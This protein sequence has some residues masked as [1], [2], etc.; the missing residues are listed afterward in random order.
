MTTNLI[1]H[2]WKNN[3]EE[4]V[5]GEALF[6]R[7]AFRVKFHIEILISVYPPSLQALHFASHF[8][9]LACDTR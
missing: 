8:S 1:D 6:I 4:H 9:L 7:H 3:K 2:H 5:Q